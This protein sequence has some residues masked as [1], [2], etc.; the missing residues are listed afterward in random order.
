MPT[1]GM[2]S[3]V[4]GIT[5]LRHTGISGNCY[6]SVCYRICKISILVGKGG[7]TTETE[8]QLISETPINKH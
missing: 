1:T 2:L 5:T 6:S 7:M 3:I 4:A 8:D